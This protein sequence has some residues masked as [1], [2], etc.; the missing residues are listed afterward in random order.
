M[1]C[2]D[3]K[4]E[5]K[6]YS[7]EKRKKSNEWFFKTGKGEYGYGDKFVGVSMPDTRKVAKKFTLLSLIET[8][9]LL[10]SKIH[11]ERMTALVILSY[12]FRRSDKENQKKIYDFYLKNTRYINNW[13]LVDVTVNR[14]LGA[15]LWENKGDRKVLH[16]LAV[17]KNMWE[18]RIAIIAT[19]YFIHQNYFTDTLK[20]SEILLNDKED[21]LHKA[22]GWMLR[23]V[24][25]RNQALEEKFLKKYY[26]I[27]PRTMLRYAI[28][29]FP[30]TKRQAYLKRNF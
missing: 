18:R 21:L 6:K 7:S 23:E 22:V 20:I 3:V 10:S 27:M 30:E 8:K 16:R 2:V 28:E 12:Q 29:R 17:S 5:L 25:K 9:S 24:G 11:E 4:N 14:I 1:K 15:Y 26:R 13:D 19:S